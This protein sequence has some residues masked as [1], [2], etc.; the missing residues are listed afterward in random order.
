MFRVILILSLALPWFIRISEDDDTKDLHA[1]CPT[2]FWRT[3]ESIIPSSV[4]NFTL[5]SQN[6][7]LPACL[8]LPRFILISEDR[9]PV[10]RRRRIPCCL[11]YAILTHSGIDNS[12]QSL[13]MFR[14]I[15]WTTN[16]C[17]WAGKR[18]GDVS[19]FPKQL[20]HRFTFHVRR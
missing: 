7:Q 2:S 13:L 4:S 8:A 15:S 1:V 19:T 17:R 16:D 3:L 12:I 18:N 5:L 14:V 11:F 20:C 6:E 10:T 9:R